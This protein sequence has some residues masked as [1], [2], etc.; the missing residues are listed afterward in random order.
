MYIWWSD[1]LQIPQSLKIKRLRECCIW[2]AQRVWPRVQLFFQPSK[3]FG[4][5]S[6]N[7]EIVR[8]VSV[9]TFIALKLVQNGNFWH[10]RP[11]LWA[12]K[13]CFS[14][15]IIELY[16]ATQITMLSFINALWSINCVSPLV[17]KAQPTQSNCRAPIQSENIL[18]SQ[19]EW[20]A[21]ESFTTSNSSFPL[22]PRTKAWKNIQ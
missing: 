13:T 17:N 18:L 16:F 8:W 12:L 14:F 21:E 6:V 5:T 4:T 7:K 19:L 22:I 10:F 9:W 11:T 3:M 20:L 1:F 2:E 15:R